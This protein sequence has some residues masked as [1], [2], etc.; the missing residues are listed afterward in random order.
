MRDIRTNDIHNV[1]TSKNFISKEKGKNLNQNNEAKQSETKRNEAKRSG[2]KR[3][4]TIN[5]FF[6]SRN[7]VKRKQN[8]LCFTSFLFEAKECKKQ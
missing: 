2:K 1:K 3:K 6:V 5:N 8:G 4:E 7:E